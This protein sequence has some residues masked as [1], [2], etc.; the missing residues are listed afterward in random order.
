MMQKAWWTAG[1]IQLTGRE[2][3]VQG[4][5][6]WNGAIAFRASLP[7]PKTPSQTG[8]AIQMI[9]NPIQL[10]RLTTTSSLLLFK[11]GAGNG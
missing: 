4:S 11:H 10:T 6:P 7:T 2:N 9:L 3:G 5:S 1:G 8:N